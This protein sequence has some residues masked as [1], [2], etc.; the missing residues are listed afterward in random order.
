MEYADLVRDAHAQVLLRGLSSRNERSLREEL[1]DYLIAVP[2][3]NLP[4]GDALLAL[5]EMLQWELSAK[6]LTRWQEVPRMPTDQRLAVWQG[7]ICS[8]QIGAIVNA[9]NE[10]GLG[11]FQPTHRCIDNVIHRAAGPGL[12]KECLQVLQKNK[13]KWGGKLPTG[14]AM[15]TKSFNLPSEFVIHTPGPVGENPEQ[16]ARCY[17]NVLERCKENRIRTVAF[18]CI[19]TGLFGY[20]AHRAAEV[21]VSTVRRWLDQAERDIE[22]AAPSRS[23]GDHDEGDAGG[24]PAP[25]KPLRPLD[26]VVFNT[27]LDSDLRV[28]QNLLGP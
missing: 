11:C 19:S 6:R 20:P 27:F 15:V 18:C 26:L 28:Y 14:E 22:A 13:L 16:L 12:R 25:P 2:P 21:A 10:Q 3:D 23:A 8:L 17:T 9:A 24:C 4:E 5:D 1:G 7:D